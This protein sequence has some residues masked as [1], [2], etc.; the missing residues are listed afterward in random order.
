MCYSLVIN[1][2]SPANG[3]PR[4]AAHALFLTTLCHAH[5]AHY[6]DVQSSVADESVSRTI[7]CVRIDCSLLKAALVE[8]C[9]GWQ[10][11]LTTLLNDRAKS[12][13]AD[14]R[15]TLCTFMR[16]SC[17]SLYAYWC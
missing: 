12:A 16:R 13:L 3:A 17:G 14:V 6:R 5:A 2:S 9:V 11:S 4:P 8:H 7:N 10:A 1:A 15:H